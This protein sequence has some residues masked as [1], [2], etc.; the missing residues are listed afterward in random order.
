MSVSTDSS[1]LT[2]ILNASLLVQVVMGLL[3]LASFMS[4]VVIFYKG[5]SVRLAKRQVTRFEDVFWTTQDFQILYTRVKSQASESG[6]LEH[7][8]EAGYRELNRQTLELGQSSDQVMTGVER[9]MKAAYQ[10]EAD[11]LE[12]NL[13]FLATV[14]SVSPYVGLLGTVWGI[15]NAFRGLANVGQTTL[16]NVA[17]GIAEALVTTATGLFVAIPAVVFYNRYTH[18]VNR[19]LGRFEGF[20]DEC[21]NVLQRSTNR[22]SRSD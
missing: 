2:L 9:A 14:G 11:V 15:M 19:L 1:F 13:P 21:A 22:K 4:W 7:I 17:P 3:L 16:A 10:R 20:M 6:A 5:F 12:N 8:F 18:E